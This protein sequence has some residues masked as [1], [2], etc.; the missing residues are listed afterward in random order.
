MN[1]FFEDLTPLEGK[2]R[3]I[4]RKRVR[5]AHLREKAAGDVFMTFKPSGACSWRQLGRHWL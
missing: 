3:L 5:Y 2:E 1:K 4:N